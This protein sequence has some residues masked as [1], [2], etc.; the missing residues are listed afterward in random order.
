MK[1]PLTAGE[2]AFI[3]ETML[4]IFIE[5]GANT[6]FEH[7]IAV[8]SQTGPD[9]IWL[10]MQQDAPGF[11]VQKNGPA[12]YSIDL[13]RLHEDTAKLHVVLQTG[14][15]AST[16]N[17]FNWVRAN[18]GSFTVEI[19]LSDLAVSC[20]VFAEV[21]R[22]DGRWKIRAKKDGVFNGI[23]ELGKRLGLQLRDLSKVRSKLERENGRPSDGAGPGAD[24]G[25]EWGGSAFLVSSSHFLTNAHVVAGAKRVLITGFGGQYE[26]EPVIVDHSN[27]L[28]LIRSARPEALAPLTLRTYPGPVLGEQAT[29]IG[30]PL[31]NVLGSGAK[32]GEGIVSGLLGPK[33]DARA[34]QITS[35]I[36]PGSSGGPVLD[37]SG[38][39]IGVVTSAILG[40]QNVNIATRVSLA[41]S[42]IEAAGV[43]VRYA[44][45]GKAIS[46][47]QLA[48][49]CVPLVWRLKCNS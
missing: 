28:A 15:D 48:R 4:E 10:P 16:L 37:S 34:F 9:R 13:S 17:S 35:P 40:T 45:E 42:L 36:Q 26:A 5:H 41:I 11:V 38:Q 19:G 33:D 23:E 7:A 2:N 49:N 18:I 32:L 21:Y 44:G 6:V 24:N 47:T 22:K 39:V 8:L 25:S 43:P 31:A 46:T 27:D 12:H 29:S 14:S 30:F 20:I 1:R 3:D